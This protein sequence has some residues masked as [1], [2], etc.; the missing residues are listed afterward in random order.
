L[1]EDAI[2]NVSV[3]YKE[4]ARALG[5]YRHEVIKEAVLLALG[6][7]LGE[8]M[9]VMLVIGSIDRLPDPIYNV[10]SSGQTITSKLGRE[11]GESAFGSTHFSVLVFMS[12]ILVILSLLLTLASQ[13]LFKTDKRH[14]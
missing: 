1:T 7:A 2:S 13:T 14:V 10:L 8:T 11:V 9:A 4:N 5:L 6:R 12:L 3:R